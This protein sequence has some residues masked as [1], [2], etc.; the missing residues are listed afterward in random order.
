MTREQFEKYYLEIDNQDKL[1]NYF[2]NIEKLKPENQLKIYNIIYNFLIEKKQK[3]NN[4]KKQYISD[5]TKSLI[6]KINYWLHLI[7]K[8]KEKILSFKKITIKK[9]KEKKELKPIIKQVKNNTKSTFHEKSFNQNDSIPFKQQ[10][11]LDIMNLE[12]DIISNNIDDIIE[13]YKIFIRTD[14]NLVIHWDYIMKIT[15]LIIQKMDECSITNK[16]IIISMIKD[17][18]KYQNT[19]I[20]KDNIEKKNNIKVL[21]K[22]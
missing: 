7:E 4:C 5:E 8:K 18:L 21:Q 13:A 2:D 17:T 16:N 9:K 6:K 15:N 20:K 11:I 22:I 10:E 12:L 14:N 3:L 19:Y 1:M